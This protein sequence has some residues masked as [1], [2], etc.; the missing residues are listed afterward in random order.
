MEKTQRSCS[1]V[2]KMSNLTP[3]LFRTGLLLVS[4]ANVF[5]NKLVDGET[6][7]M[8]ARLHTAPG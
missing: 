7:S 5:L 8:F 3:A 4:L 6:K 1:P 2:V